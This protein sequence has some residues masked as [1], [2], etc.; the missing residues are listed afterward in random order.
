MD[1]YFELFLLKNID[2]KRFYQVL[3]MCIFHHICIFFIMYLLFTHVH[4]FI[5]LFFGMYSELFISFYLKWQLT[6]TTAIRIIS[7]RQVVQLP[8]VRVRPPLRLRAH[9]GSEQLHLRLVLLGGP[10]V[11]GGPEHRQPLAPEH[12]QRGLLEA[13]PLLQGANTHTHTA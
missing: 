11:R 4:P 3:S 2:K 1:A 5:S 8:S 6:R 10:R 13:R 9:P 7:S 12:K